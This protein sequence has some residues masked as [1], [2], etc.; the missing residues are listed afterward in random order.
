MKSF[1]DYLIE[2]ELTEGN[3]A[4]GDY[5]DLEI[6]RDETLIE[7]YI[8]DVFEDGIVLEADDTMIELLR[9]AGYLNEDSNMPT[10]RDS[11]SPIHS[12]VNKDKSADDDFIIIAG[13]NQNNIGVLNNFVPFFWL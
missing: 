5:F 9:H 13:I 10:A 8:V 4:V 3:P 1:S 11:I 12:N 2:A 7:T 6:A